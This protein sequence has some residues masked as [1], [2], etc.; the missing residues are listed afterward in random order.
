MD[1]EDSDDP[2][3][4]D[5]NWKDLAQQRSTSVTISQPEDV[6]ESINLHVRK[7]RRMIDDLAAQAGAPADIRELWG[8]LAFVLGDWKEI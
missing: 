3:D 8:M 2:D 4:D 7:L 5:T 6:A 1:M